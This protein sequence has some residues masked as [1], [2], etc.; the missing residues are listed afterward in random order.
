MPLVIGSGHTHTHR[1][2][3]IPTREQ[4]QETT[5]AGMRPMHAWFKKLF[6]NQIDYYRLTQ[7]AGCSVQS[8]P[9][10]HDYVFATEYLLTKFVKCRPTKFW[11]MQGM[12]TF[13]TLLLYSVQVNT[14]LVPTIQVLWQKYTIKKKIYPRKKHLN[15][16]MTRISIP[17]EGIFFVL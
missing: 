9:V 2:T 8:Y 12:L 5:C 1:H 6:T 16:S 14:K 10:I 4:F 11:T 15:N 17:W 7:Q 13:V 3:H